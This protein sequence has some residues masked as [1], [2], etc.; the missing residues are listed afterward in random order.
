MVMSY[1]GA[2]PDP[3]K[4]MQQVQVKDYMT[5]KLVTFNP[6]QSM[7]EVI[8][9]LL[10]SNISGAPVVDADNH[11]VG[12]ISE[13]DCLKQVIRGK[14][15]NTFHDTGKVGDRMSTDVKTITPGMNVFEA[16]QMFLDLKLRRFPVLDEGKLVGQI[17]QQDIMRA[18]QSLKKVTW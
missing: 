5:K 3:P 11:L 4:E 6:E 1:Q 12:I 8:D 17:S 16:A 15:N 2:R 10:A 9:T 13:G 14:Y 18:I 7:D